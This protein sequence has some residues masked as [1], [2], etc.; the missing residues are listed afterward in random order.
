MDKA[1]ADTVRLMLAVAPAV[2]ENA[3][4]AMKGGTAINLFVQNMPRLSV[5]I[6]V[7]YLPRQVPRDDALQAI[8]QELAA[9]A[10]RIAPLGVQ[11]RLV[12]SRDLG[13]TKM[14]VENEST[15]VK[16]EVNTVFRGTVLPTASL[17]LSPGTADRF[18]V[19]FDVPVL[20]SDELYGGK[21]VAAMDRQHP[22]DL[23]DVWQLYQSGGITDG[24]VECFV[25]YLAGHNRPIHEVLFGNDKDIATEYDRAFVGITLTP[26][27]LPTLLDARARIRRELPARLSAQ[28]RQFLIGLAHAEPDWSLLSCPHAAELPALRWKLS[29]LET[30]RQRRPKDFSAQVETLEARLAAH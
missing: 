6:D 19:E 28:H 22:R 1:Y 12:R 20:A 10:G 21:L 13:D 3:I 25:V 7:V 24:M 9:V 5:D 26:C 2:F 18:G 27:P 14:I 17:P 8:N 23:Y 4:F 15:Q 11:T 16:V 30:F 29:N